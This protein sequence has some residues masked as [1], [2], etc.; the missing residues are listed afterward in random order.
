MTRNHRLDREINYDPGAGTSALREGPEVH[1]SAASGI[2][3]RL[4]CSPQ[5]RDVV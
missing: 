1:F 4:S 3:G 2:G 5:A